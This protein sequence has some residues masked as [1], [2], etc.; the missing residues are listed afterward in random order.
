MDDSDRAI[1]TLKSAGTTDT[2]VFEICRTLTHY[3]MPPK[4]KW[5][6]IKKLLK[7]LKGDGET[8]RRPILGYLNSIM[9]NNGDDTTFFM[10]QP[11][12]ENFM[13]SGKAGLTMAC[14][15]AIFNVDE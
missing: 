14:Y 15:T 12:K 6:K 4:T 13:Y 1:N 8:A 2:E 5:L 3:N 7:D 11:F 10:M 9:L